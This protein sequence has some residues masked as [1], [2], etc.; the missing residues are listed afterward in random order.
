MSYQTNNS[1]GYQRPNPMGYGHHA[2]GGMPMMGSAGVYGGAPVV[3][4]PA[5]PAAPVAQQAKPYYRCWDNTQKKWFYW[6]KDSSVTTWTE[7]AAHITIIDHE[8]GSIV[9]RDQPPIVSRPPPPVVDHTQASGVSASSAAL[10]A[11]AAAGYATGRQF[12]ASSAPVVAG[13]SQ[14][15]SVQP[16]ASSAPTR[17]AQPVVSHHAS[18][19]V[20]TAQR[21]SV[22][23][24]INPNYSAGVSRYTTAGASGSASAGRGG[25]SAAER[26]RIEEADRAIAEQL[27]KQLSMEAEAE[28]VASCPLPGEAA[29][30]IAGSKKKA[31]LKGPN[32]AS[33]KAEE[34]E[35]I[36][37]D[38]A[39]SGFVIKKQKQKKPVATTG[40]DATSKK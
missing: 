35:K 9:Q 8:T 39:S 32:A 38:M 26:A 7:P 28:L 14:P 36:I 33:K 1:Y 10:G 17:S 34:D 31:N 5:P 12:Q 22:P 40:G 19:A 24:T 6:E 27:Q 11:N 25:V 30:M 20:T 16:A 15:I 37:A 29:K 2:Q 13:V 18:A 3:S 4:F 21:S 23:Q